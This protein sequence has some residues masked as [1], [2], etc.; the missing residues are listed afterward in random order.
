MSISDATI[1]IKSGDFEETIQKITSGIPSNHHKGGQS[2]GRYARKREE[3][4]KEYARRVESY[5]KNVVVDRW[6]IRGSNDVLKNF[7]G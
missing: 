4:I 3:A 5:T 6:E 2:Q 7:R 1:A